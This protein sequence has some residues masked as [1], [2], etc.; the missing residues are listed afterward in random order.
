MY[1]KDNI[2]VLKN[3]ENTISNNCII[4]EAEGGEHA[5]SII[6]HKVNIGIV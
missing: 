6:L 4:E 3:S 1:A 2:I 5:W